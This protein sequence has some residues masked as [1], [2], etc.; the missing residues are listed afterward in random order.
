M[1]M[2]DT[3]VFEDEMT[4]AMDAA[5]AHGLEVT[6]IHNHFTYDDP[7]V[8]FMHIGGMGDAAKLAEGVKAVWDGI[9]ARRAEVP[10]PVRTSDSEQTVVQ[11]ELDDAQLEEILTVP[12]EV[13][14]NVVKF[15]F[16][17][18]GKMHGV[19]VGG[20]MGLTTW[21]AFIG[22][23]D[24]AAVD[25]DFMMIAEEVQPVLHALREN[26]IHVVALHNHMIGEDPASY[27]LHYWGRG[28]AKDLAEGILAAIDAQKSVNSPR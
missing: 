21:A 15:T 7:P 6:G 14:A 2:G 19:D 27:F 3:V 25:G 26:G 10:M 18:Q 8:Y 5:F 28:P 24:N 4:I 17:K 23:N 11:G 9:K 22:S 16:P 12:A 13:S 1:V 20:S